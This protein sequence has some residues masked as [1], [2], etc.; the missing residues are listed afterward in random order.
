[1]AGRPVPAACAGRACRTRRP[2][3]T[4]SWCG[5]L[6]CGVCR[7]DLHVL[8]GDL[9]VTRHVW[10]PATRRSAWS[11]HAAGRRHAR[12]SA[13]RW[14]SLAAPHLRRVPRLPRR[15]ARTCA[16]ARRTPAGTPTA[17]TRSWLTVPRRLRLPVARRAR[18]RGSARRCCAP[19]SSATG[20]CAAPSCRRG[21]A[22]GL[23]GFGGSAHLTAQVAI[24][25]GATVHVMTRSARSRQARARPG[26]RVRPGL[27]RPPAGAAGLGDPVRAR[28]ATWSRSRSRRSRPGGTLA[29][30]GIHLSQI[31]PLDYSAARVPREAAALGRGEHS[32]RR[33]RAA[34]ARRDASACGVITPSPT[35]FG[36]ALDDLRAW[37]VTCAEVLACPEPIVAG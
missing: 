1:M 36:P 37:T 28:P 34:R 21:G 5:S 13:T 20:R 33:P 6:A 27:D 10:S 3:T 25:E 4:S 18:P 30:A 9:P 19:G 24:A 32:G 14:G 16:P 22:L 17:A 2:P 8:D 15:A 12:G 31:P 23:Y 7:T 35:T 29:V 11:S 26:L